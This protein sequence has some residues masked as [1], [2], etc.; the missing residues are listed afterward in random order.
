MAR[1]VRI[2]SRMRKGT[3]RSIARQALERIVLPLVDPL[4]ARLRIQLMAAAAAA[5]RCGDVPTAGA[6][7]TQ[8][9]A[10]ARGTRGSGGGCPRQHLANL[11]GQ[12]QRIGRFDRRQLQREHAA[13]D[14]FQVGEQVGLASRLFG[15]QQDDVGHALFDGFDRDDARLGADELAAV[16]LA[17]KAR[18]RGAVAVSRVEGEDQGHDT[19]GELISYKIT[20]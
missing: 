7:P 10:E 4:C 19:V 6:S 18:Q 9:R 15:G 17:R 16:Q 14:R 1:R 20:A 11:P 13:W 3:R 12:I 5:S 2:G 8:R